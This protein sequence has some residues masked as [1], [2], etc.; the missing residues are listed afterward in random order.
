M[1]ALGPARAL[2]RR[3]LASADLEVEAPAPRAAAP[4]RQAG[5]PRMPLLLGSSVVSDGR[6]AG[7]TLGGDGRAPSMP[8]CLGSARGASPRDSA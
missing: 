4:A 2:P 1:R 8:P 3:W 6:S 7:A 5:R